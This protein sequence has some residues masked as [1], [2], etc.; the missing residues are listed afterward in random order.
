MKWQLPH[1]RPWHPRYL[2]VLPGRL[3]L[4]SFPRRRLASLAQLHLLAQHR[5]RLPSLR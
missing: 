2:P 3:P 1:Q 4:A 5:A